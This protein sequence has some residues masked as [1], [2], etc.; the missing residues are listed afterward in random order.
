MP[1]FVSVAIIYWKVVDDCSYPTLS[2]YSLLCVSL[3]VNNTNLSTWGYKDVDQRFKYYH[4]KC[5]FKSNILSYLF[6]YMISVNIFHQVIVSTFVIV[7]I[8]S[9]NN[10]CVRVCV[11][12]RKSQSETNILFLQKFL[13]PFNYINFFFVYTH[14][15]INICSSCFLEKVNIMKS[16]VLTSITFPVL[17]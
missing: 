2:V 12:V 13:T 11:C 14:P 5:F 1:N 9:A 3:C 15:N 10:V 7:K 17:I 16:N 4:I 8:W 6:Y